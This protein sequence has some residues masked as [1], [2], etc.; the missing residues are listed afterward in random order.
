[1]HILALTTLIYPV[2][3]GIIEASIHASGKDDRE[4]L[5]D[6]KEWAVGLHRTLSLGSV[7]NFEPPKIHVIANIVL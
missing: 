2:V 6:P 7:F 5:G 4:T 1:M 3:I